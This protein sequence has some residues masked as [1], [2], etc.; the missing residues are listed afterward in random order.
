MVQNGR[1]LAENR[2]LAAELHGSWRIAPAAPDEIVRRVDT[3]PPLVRDLLTDTSSGRPDALSPARFHELLCRRVDV[4]GR[5]AG[6]HEA[7][8]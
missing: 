1:T 3:D 5:A 7:H 6:P 4:R 8:G 2:E